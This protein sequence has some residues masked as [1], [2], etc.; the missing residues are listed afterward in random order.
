MSTK[1]IDDVE[2]RMCVTCRKNHPLADYIIQSTSF[3]KN[4]KEYK[5]CLKCRKF[6][7]EYRRKHGKQDVNEKIT[8]DCGVKYFPSRKQAH[9]ETKN[10]FFNMFKIERIQ[11]KEKQKQEKEL[12]K[13]ELKHEE[14]KN[15]V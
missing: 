14:I 4:K 8:C 10:H 11:R 3:L 6:L 9:L 2:N 15:D 1:S 13:N 5:T 12:K 7:I